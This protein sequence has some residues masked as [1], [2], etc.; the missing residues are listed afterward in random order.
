M[1]ETIQF[2][3]NKVV[4]ILKEMVGGVILDITALEVDGTTV[5]DIADLNKASLE[6]A[7]FRNGSSQPEYF[8]NDYLDYI[9]RGITSAWMGYTI[10]TT[11][12]SKGYLIAI[13]FNGSLKLNE[14]DRIEVIFKVQT[15]AFTDLS[16]ADSSIDIETFP[17]T[18]TSPVISVIESHTFITGSTDIDKSLG[19]NIEKI[20]YVGDLTADYE[21]S[22][23][24]KPTNGIILTA[25]GFEKRVSENTLL[26]EN[27]SSLQANPETAIKN[28]VLYNDYLNPKTNVRLTSKLDK[29]VDT[30]ARLMIVRKRIL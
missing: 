9:L 20:V 11:K 7:V 1:K 18:M 15:D 28:L 22:T 29:A 3:S 24:A 5:A 30:D 19:N 10:A 8:C 12:R 6:I 23:K 21:A 2:N 13:P 4:T 26:T 14:G 17:A 16:T 25:S 27:L